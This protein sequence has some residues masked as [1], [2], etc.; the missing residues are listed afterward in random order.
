MSNE[1]TWVFRINSLAKMHCDNKESREPFYYPVTWVSMSFHNGL[2]LCVRFQ[3]SEAHY[4][5]V[6]RS[7]AQLDFYV[8]MLG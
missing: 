1:G 6:T 5:K 4:R 7:Q 2:K 3:D 8:L